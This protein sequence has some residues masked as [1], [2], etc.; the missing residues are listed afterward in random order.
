M[1]YCAELRTALEKEKEKDSDFMFAFETD[2]DGV[3]LRAAWSPPLA[4]RYAMLFTVRSED[5]LHCHSILKKW[6]VFACTLRGPDLNNLTVMTALIK[7]ESAENFYWLHR[8]QALWFGTNFFGANSVLMTDESA[9]MEHALETNP[10]TYATTK[11][12]LCQWHKINKVVEHA[13]TVMLAKDAER[14]KALWWSLF[15]AKNISEAQLYWTKIVKRA[16]AACTSITTPRAPTTSATSGSADLMCSGVSASGAQTDVAFDLLE[17]DL[18]VGG[19]GLVNALLLAVEQLEPA[20]RDARGVEHRSPKLLFWAWLARQYALRHKLVKCL[21][22]YLS[23]SPASKMQSLPP[24]RPRFTGGLTSSSISE[25]VGANLN[26]IARGKLVT[27]SQLLRN[28]LELLHQQHQNEMDRQQTKHTISSDS[29]TA[30]RLVRRMLGEHTATSDTSERLP[31][32]VT[33]LGQIKSRFQAPA[34]NIVLLSDDAAVTKEQPFWLVGEKKIATDNAPLYHFKVT[35]VC[36][37]V[38]LSTDPVTRAPIVRS[39]VWWPLACDCQDFVLEGLPCCHIFQVLRCYSPISIA[40]DV[41]W[42]SRPSLY[43]APYVHPHYLNM[44]PTA[45]ALLKVNAALFNS[46]SAV[47]RSE[48]EQ[49][50]SNYIAPPSTVPASFSED[51]ESA[52]MLPPL[53]VESLQAC[54]LLFNKLCSSLGTQRDAL[55][56]L[57]SRLLEF[58]REEGK[59]AK[60]L[61]KK[62]KQKSKHVDIIHDE[63]DAPPT[64]P[65]DPTLTAPGARSAHSSR[66]SARYSEA[67]KQ[68]RV[69]PRK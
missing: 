40:D 47:H 17:P 62:E 6:K 23:L 52:V 61:Q 14:W 68:H 5:C 35:A 69:N 16:W 29:K 38:H 51:H 57:H 58:E 66:P 55:N 39:S 24:L 31:L 2:S 13:G 42:R 28:S 48:V 33:I 67:A 20:T 34:S 7:E 64:L 1:S 49:L 15:K 65:I 53:Q 37:D 32:G 60:E 44:Y 25:G 30:A 59:L 18:I 22:G 3:F 41:E 27:P 11:H 50:F 8:L 19:S 9:G 46:G 12:L 54:T 56:R 4:R 21:Y 10:K 45:D 43:I 36:K 63:I 26:R